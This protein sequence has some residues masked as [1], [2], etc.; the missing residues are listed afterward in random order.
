LVEKSIKEANLKSRRRSI[1]RRVEFHGSSTDIP[2]QK[3][4]PYQAS[5]A[6]R[7]ASRVARPCHVATP[8]HVR[9]APVILAE[10]GHGNPM[11]LG[12]T[13]APFSTARLK[14][15]S[16]CFHHYSVFISFLSLDCCFHV[17]IWLCCIALVCSLQYDVNSYT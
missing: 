8:Y 7:P 9:G 4:R 17:S 10:F 13:M 1:K 11:P 2:G 16:G 14:F 5:T 3:V 6:Q 15:S 12:T